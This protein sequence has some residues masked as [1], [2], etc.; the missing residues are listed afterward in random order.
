MEIFFNPALQTQIS[1]PIFKNNPS[2]KNSTDKKEV[3]TPKIVLSALALAGITTLV[4]VKIKG[5][6]TGSKKPDLKNLAGKTMKKVKDMTREEK[7]KFIKELQVKTDNS[8]TK[9]EIRKLVESGE[10]D[11]L[12]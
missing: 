6:K 10:W 9:E 2:K 8:A 11:N 4:I 7:E 3:S 5:K 12:G 1:K